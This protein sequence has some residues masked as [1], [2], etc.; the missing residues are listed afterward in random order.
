MCGQ[1]EAVVSTVASLV[2]LWAQ[3][4]YGDSEGV[5]GALWG[6]SQLV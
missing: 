2:S 3:A 1:P 6:C 4:A 5:E